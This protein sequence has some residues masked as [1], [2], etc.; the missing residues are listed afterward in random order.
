MSRGELSTRVGSA[1]ERWDEIGELGKDFNRMSHQLERLVSGQKRLLADISHE[2]RSPLA[3]LQVAIGIAQ[4][5]SSDGNDE[6]L[7][8][9]LNRIEKEAH[10]IED[11][12]GQVLTLSRLEA[13]PELQKQSVD[14]TGLIK[15]L[16]DDADYEAQASGKHVELT[17]D[18][19][20]SVFA[21]SMILGSALSNIIRNAVKYA[22]AKVS[23][24]TRLEQNQAIVIVED[25]GPGVDAQQLEHIFEPFYRLS[26]S[27]NRDSG[28]VGLGL[29]ITQQ[30]IHSHR[31]DILAENKHPQGLRIRVALPDASQLS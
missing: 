17:N 14:L 19:Q 12:I 21:D 6:K 2:L 29:A 4:Q 28:G 8:K 15:G 22:E 24:V 23:V 16:V 5:T 9:H 20:I 3:R 26:A 31:G 10:E 11:M 27:R 13:M 7:E 30:A 18:D 1:S 25:D